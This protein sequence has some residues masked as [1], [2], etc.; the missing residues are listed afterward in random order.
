MNILRLLKLSGCS[1]FFMLT[2]FQTK[3][4]TDNNT[5]QLQ[6]LGCRNNKGHLLVSLFDQ[7]A[8]FPAKTEKAVK[9]I[10]LPIVNGHAGWVI[11]GLP[12]GKYA[13]AVLHDE[14]DDQKMNTS[15]VG[16]PKEGYGFSNNVMG[17]MGPPSFDKA[18]FA[19]TED[20]SVVIN[21]RY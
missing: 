1:I 7:S 10:S 4:V 12:A 5:I 8:G 13:V 18:A 11:N 3:T 14:N 19:V 15:F 16:L 9:R 17:A 21:I 2:A 20:L 6:I